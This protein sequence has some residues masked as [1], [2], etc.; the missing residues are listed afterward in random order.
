MNS[1]LILIA[2]FLAVFWEAA[3]HGIHS[4]LG[5]QIHLLPGLVVYASLST[6]LLT[7]SLTAIVGGLFFDSLSANPL[8]VTVLPLCLI[9]IAIYSQRELI[10]RD[11]FF[12]QFVLGLAASALV[13]VLTALLILT[14][15]EPPLLGWGSAWQWIVVSVGGAVATPV[16]FQVLGLFDRTLN[17]RR[18]TETSF[19]LDREI[20]RGRK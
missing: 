20:R 17:Y 11:Q 14:K 8:G 13:P 19:R 7:T 12:A 10:L 6:G 1:I 3:F 16:W 2:A 15:G 4:L 9:G 5:A 18:A